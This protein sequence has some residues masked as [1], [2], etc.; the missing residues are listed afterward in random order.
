VLPIDGE[1]DDNERD[2]AQKGR[3]CAP[4]VDSATKAPDPGGPRPAGGSREAWQ[5]APLRR[6]ACRNALSRIEGAA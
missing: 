1:S 2:G 4:C 6:A 5:K 3:T